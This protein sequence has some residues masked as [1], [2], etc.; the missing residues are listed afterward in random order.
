MNGHVQYKRGKITSK[1]SYWN[2]CRLK[3]IVLEHKAGIYKNSKYYGIGSNIVGVSNLYDTDSI[4][5]QI[6]DLVQLSKDELKEY[7]LKEGDL[8]Y[9]ES[10]LVKEGIA[11]TL[12]V[13]RE[14][15][16]T[17]FAWHTRRFRVDRDIIE[18]RF[19][20]CLL[21][22]PPVRKELMRVATQTALTGITTKDFFGVMIAYPQKSE[23]ERI[24]EILGC[25]DKAIEKTQ[26]LIRSKQTLKK[27]LMQQLLTG[28]KRFKEFWGQEWK[29]FE[30]ADIA[31]LTKEK[32]DPR[33]ERVNYKCIEL[34]HIDQESGQLLGHVD[35]SS[36]LC[37]KNRFSKG[38]VLFGKLRPYLRKY[39][40]ANFDGVCSTEIWAIRAKENVCRRKFLFYIIQSHSFNLAANVTS[41]TKMPRSDW[42]YVSE[43]PFALPSL[44]EQRKIAAVLNSCDKEIEVLRSKLKVLKQQ[45]KGLMQKLLTGKIRVKV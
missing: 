10:S 42:K 23:Q 37:I 29:T 13:T 5:G 9:G 26:K 4:N 32:Y 34:E 35:S 40:F 8:I 41:G 7:T 14:G 38:D 1:P 21:N 31:T 43:V 6:F 33:K 20:N 11:R 15:E 3:D 45:K 25:W 16:G 24:A 27:A 44:Q 22:S 30:F 36:Q 2:K 39:F 18:S 12:Y 19:L 28:K 17:A